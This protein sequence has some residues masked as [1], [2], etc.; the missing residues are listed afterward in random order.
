MEFLNKRQPITPAPTSNWLMMDEKAIKSNFDFS[1]SD[2]AFKTSPLEFYPIGAKDSL[3]RTTFW[4]STETPGRLKFK[5]NMSERPEPFTLDALQA[6]IARHDELEAGR[7]FIYSD[8]ESG[9]DEE[10][11]LPPPPPAKTVKK[12]PVIINLPPGKAPEQ[13]NKETNNSK[14]ASNQRV[15]VSQKVGQKFSKTGR[16]HIYKFLDWEKKN[17]EIL[18]AKPGKLSTINQATRR[19]IFQHVERENDPKELFP[20]IKKKKVD[21]VTLTDMGFDTSFQ[22]LMR[23][24]KSEQMR[25]I[26]RQPENEKVAPKI[27]L[28]TGV[29]D[30]KDLGLKKNSIPLDSHQMFDNRSRI[31]LIQEEDPMVSEKKKIRQRE[32][33]IEEDDTPVIDLTSQP[34]LPETKL[35]EEFEQAR[36]FQLIKQRQAANSVD[37]FDYLVTAPPF[38]LDSRGYLAVDYIDSLAAIYSKQPVRSLYYFYHGVKILTHENNILQ[39]MAKY[40]YKDLAERE[41]EIS[42]VHLQFTVA[43]LEGKTSELAAVRDRPRFKY[44]LLKVGLDDKITKEDLEA[45]GEQEYKMMIAF[46]NVKF[47]ILDKPDKLN[48]NDPVEH[49]VKVANAHIQGVLV[50][51]NNFKK[52]EE[53]L[54]KKWKEFLKFCRFKV[55]EQYN[56]KSSFLFT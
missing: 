21:W 13:I 51:A 54:K 22:Q 56:L 30:S 39:L 48:L 29:L 15:R 49:V 52:N 4:L 31:G 53:F 35:A 43:Q 23:I 46:F 14:P 28:S 8:M 27:F 3:S 11:E 41:K 17:E 34:I 2:L 1:K 36:S 5:C 40:D 38:A 12:G 16:T 9:T 20:S 50:R 25:E 6:A 24:T 26:T 7:G 18:Q 37:K 47:S 45:L 55:K 10:Q 33:I 32:L 19:K 44:I 42:Y